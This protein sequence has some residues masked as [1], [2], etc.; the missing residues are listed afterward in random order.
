MIVW[1]CILAALAGALNPVQSGANG[2]L[3]RVL[4][5]PFGVVLVSLSV[6]LAFTLSAGLLTR[7]GAASGL[8]NLMEAPWWAWAGGFCGAIFLAS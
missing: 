5:N 7:A 6:S 2:E 8:S 1:L 4:G 3:G